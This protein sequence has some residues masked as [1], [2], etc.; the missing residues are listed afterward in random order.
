M[1]E[2]IDKKEVD[3][4]EFEPVRRSGKRDQPVS[5]GI[6]ILL[7]L[8]FGLLLSGMFGLIALF[9]LGIAALLLFWFWE[10]V[11]RLPIFFYAV[12]FLL[13]GFMAWNFLSSGPVFPNPIASWIYKNTGLDMRH[14]E[15]TVVVSDDDLQPAPAQQS[16]APTDTL[17]MEPE[18]VNPVNEQAPAPEKQDE[19][20]A[21][22]AKEIAVTPVS[23]DSKAFDA[24]LSKGLKAVEDEQ[25][26]VA[27]Q[28]FK[29]AFKA[30]PGNP[31]LK[32]LAAEFK[33]TG[34]EKCQDFK[35]ANAKELMHIPNNYYQYSA[36]LTQTVP[37]KCD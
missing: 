34:D 1:R 32:E 33:K 9:P 4:T 16:P 10:R 3:M 13:V 11:V 5:L 19:T 30:S 15:Q 29:S 14:T 27:N 23:T 6:P 8:I 35:S 20:A 17:T 21:E 2:N 18:Q 7:F 12:F 28:N 22:P 36:S 37:L 31:R 25:Y 26:D 24:F